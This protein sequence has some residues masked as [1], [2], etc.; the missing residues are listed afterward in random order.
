MAYVPGPP[1]WVRPNSTHASTIALAVSA[2]ICIFISVRLATSFDTVTFDSGAGVAPCAHALAATKVIATVNADFVIMGSPVGRPLQGRRKAGL[3]GRPTVPPA[4]RT[5]R[6][7]SPCCLRPSSPAASPPAPALYAGSTGSCERETE[8][9]RRCRYRGSRRNPPD[10]GCRR[11][12]SAAPSASAA[13][14]LCS[15]RSTAT[16]AS[17]PAERRRQDRHRDR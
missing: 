8:T 15:R 12:A 17:L 6:L 7:R 13:T 9:S 4:S 14:G 3:K 5:S 16:P 10:R 2:L 11:L 1:C